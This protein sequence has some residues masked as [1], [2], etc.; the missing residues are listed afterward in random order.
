MKQCDWG[1]D[2]CRADI[3][4][5]S[6]TVGTLARSRKILL[7][8]VS[9]PA[10]YGIL[11]SPMMIVAAWLWAGSPAHAAAKFWQV[12]TGNWEAASSWTGG[13]PGAADTASIQNSPDANVSLST[14]QS[15]LALSMSGGIM[16]IH[17]GGALSIAQAATLDNSTLLING[18]LTLVRGVNV[19][20]GGIL[21]GN[22]TL[23]T[24]GGPTR[25]FI[26]NADAFAAPGAV[27][28]IGTLTVNG[29]T[30]FMSGSTYEVHLGANGVGDLLNVVGPV[31][32]RAGAKLSIMPTSGINYANG[33]VYDVLKGTSINNTFSNQSAGGDF[34]TFSQTLV[35]TDGV[36]GNDTLR[37]AITGVNAPIPP[38]D[39]A[40]ALSPGGSGVIATQ[41]YTGALAFKSGSTY[42]VDI[43]NNGSGDKV[44]ATGA[45]TIE[46]GARIAISPMSDV[47]FK[48]GWTY[49]VVKGDTIAGLFSSQIVAGD[50]ATFSQ[51]LVDTDRRNGEDTLRLAI[52]SLAPPD[53]T[54]RA[55]TPNQTAVAGG[56][57]SV[58]PTSPVFNALYMVRAGGSVAAFDQ[59]SGEIHGSATS[60]LIQDSHFIREAINDRI[61]GAFDSV[62]A[63]RMAV[64][65]YAPDRRVSAGHDAFASMP[66]KA[67]PGESPES[68]SF[69]MWGSAFGSWGKLAGD[70]NAAKV[71]RQAAGFL[72]GVDTR[73]LDNWQVGAF[74][75]YSQ[76]FFDTRRSKGS[77]DGYH[78]GGY[79]GTA[80]GGLSLR[81]GVAYAWHDIKTTRDIS[82]DLIGNATFTDKAIA[83]YKAQ[84]LQAFGDIGY[85]IDVARDIA[86]E[87]FA[88]AA[89]VRL[90]TDQFKETGGSAALTVNKSSTGTTF[91]TVG[92]RAATAFE[93]DDFQTTIRGTVGWRHAFG[94][95]DP[96]STQA[97]ATG[98]AFTIAGAPI[99]VNAI[100]AEAGLDF[101]LSSSAVVAVAYNGQFGQTLWENGVNANLKVK[102]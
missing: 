23:T 24:T 99:D 28:Q 25:V 20:A 2:E 51:T 40:G 18:S 33:W 101:R 43:G 41:N 70:G 6:S 49:D 87:P 29:Q 89:Y 16:T 59:L 36:G 17:S 61:R 58:N 57:N 80:W 92:A 81:S 37:I 38:I 84:S 45:I 12:T 11:L 31:D 79:I 78:I 69:A 8:N 63:P 5:R 48:N 52:T 98:N 71:D 88:N 56:L 21:G 85:R 27:G 4:R 22:G 66:L 83:D 10:R 35:D 50:F 60:S 74:G 32:I 53:F 90:D 67:Q 75:G 68:E 7:A 95:I 62:A 97:F 77:S 76:S 42:A 96:R 30:R 15:I 13:V 54:K 46:N 44:V 91:T 1:V 26:F 73:V 14:A 34:A 9:T 47:L 39:I 19:N 55:V 64:T 102:F 65:S 93:V 94:D 82:I 100:V 72:L 3:A 86:I